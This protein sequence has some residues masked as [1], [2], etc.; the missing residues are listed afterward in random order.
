[1]QTNIKRIFDMTMAFIIGILTL[2]IM[3]IAAIIVKLESPGP[4]IIVKIE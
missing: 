1:M 3:G 4:I 2:P